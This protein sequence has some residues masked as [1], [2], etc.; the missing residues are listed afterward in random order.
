[1]KWSTDQHTTEHLVFFHYDVICF[2]VGLHIYHVFNQSLK[3]NVIV[4]S[5]KHL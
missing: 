3:M 5:M 4:A 2:D 1:M